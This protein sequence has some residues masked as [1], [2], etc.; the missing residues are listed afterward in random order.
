MLRI[1]KVAIARIFSDLIKA[2]RII[3]AGEMECWRRICGK[4]SIDNDARREAI[5]I[6]LARALELLCTAEMSGLKE[7]FMANCRSMAV[8]DGFCAHSEALLMAALATVLDDAWPLY[9]K[10]F[11]IP[12]TDFNI[13][14]GTVLYI[15]N[16]YHSATNE[17]I[18]NGYRSIFK[19]LQLAGFH[20]VYIP[21]IINHYSTT[22]PALLKDILS[23]LSPSMSNEALDH[24]YSAL[25]GMTT[26]GF[27]KDLL[28]NKCGMTEL[29][30]V[31]PS[32]LIKIGDSFV[33]EN[34]YADY[35]C[36]DIGK[37]VVGT[38]R[39]FVDCFCGMLSGDVAVVS[40]SGDRDGRFYFH[41][42]YKQLLDIFLMRRNIRSVVHINPYR[43]EI[44]FPGI[45]AK[46]TGVHRREKALYALL[47]CQGSEGVD[48]SA[49]ASADALGSY[50]LRMQK[51]QRRYEAI[52]EMFG[53]EK[54]AAPDLGLP[55]IRRPIFSCLKRSLR[56]L[57]GLYNPQD[58]N[59]TKN[60]DGS[61][62]VHVEP[63]LVYVCQSGS[64]RPVPLHLSYLYQV[65][66]GI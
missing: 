15:E 5:D 4:Y 35:L 42:F 2:D 10:V 52:Y 43:E 56:N 63:D 50:N 25:M 7:D 11:S 64:E 6:P 55:E 33:G 21:E 53:G 48:F 57:K 29:R 46:A 59:V 66:K 13:D 41:G 39:A 45:D 30:S 49:P 36:I 3:D 51:I 22:D 40:A 19:E 38:V 58:Y 24:V 9:G 20:F 14:I 8:S 28:C 34:Q 12:R 32:L 54:G 23:F 26:G 18:R 44:L 1:H 16:E 31:S 61:F 27:C 62:S 47:L 17:A 37:D 65:W 60:A